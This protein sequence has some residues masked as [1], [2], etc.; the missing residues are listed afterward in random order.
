MIQFCFKDELARQE[1]AEEPHRNFGDGAP[2]PSTVKRSYNEFERDHKLRLQATGDEAYGTPLK[3]AITP[4]NID[5]VRPMI[6]EDSRITYNDIQA[7]L[8][9]GRSE[10]Q[11]ISPH[12]TFV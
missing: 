1:C 6:R 4:E 9:S 11:N 3:T 12:V 7:S 2:L 10:V 5:T 8:G